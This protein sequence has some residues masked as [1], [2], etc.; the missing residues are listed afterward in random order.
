MEFL[1]SIHWHFKKSTLERVVVLTSLSS[2]P[3]ELGCS[4]SHHTAFWT[5]ISSCGP[6]ERLVMWGMHWRVRQAWS[7]SL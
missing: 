1:K 2:M 6:Q 7:K 5:E 3:L 4:L